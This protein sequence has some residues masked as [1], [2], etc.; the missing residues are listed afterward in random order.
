LFGDRTAMNVIVLD[1][2]EGPRRM[3]LKLHEGMMTWSLRASS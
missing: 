2:G 3:W 1:S